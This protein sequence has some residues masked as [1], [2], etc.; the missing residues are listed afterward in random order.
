MAEPR[1][2]ASDRPGCRILI[3]GTGGQGVVL[4]ARLLTT[5]FHRLGL[6]VV[7]GQLHGMAQRGGAVQST[8]MVNRGI[9][10]AIPLGGADFVLGYEPV[11]TAR[12]LPYMSSRSTV[13][14]NTAP[15]VPFVLSQEYVREGA[16]KGEY[17]EFEVLAASIRSVAPRLIVVD[18]TELAERAGSLKTLNV[19]ML[20]CLFGSEA[21]P[22][23]PREF[24]DTVMKGAPARLAEINMRAFRS[25]VELGERVELD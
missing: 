4:S 12:A 11:E 3:A 15:I 5:F 17:P 6:E 14:M 9:S 8:V 2:R 13:F 7:S 19:V 18:A 24:E 20:G 23:A 22:F 10:P 25:G 16:E 1:A 21:F